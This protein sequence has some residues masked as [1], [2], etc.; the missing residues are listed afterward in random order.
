M[1]LMFKRHSSSRDARHDNYILP[2]NNTSNDSPSSKSSPESRQ[3]LAF[4]LSLSLSPFLFLSL[5]SSSRMTELRNG[6]ESITR[7]P[8]P[9]RDS[10]GVDGQILRR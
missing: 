6:K 9:D 2:V 1:G 7:Q 3:S 4:S 10:G 8:A 5:D